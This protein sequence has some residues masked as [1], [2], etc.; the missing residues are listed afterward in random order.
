MDAKYDNY[1]IGLDLGTSAIKLV[2][3]DA[4]GTLLACSRQEYPTLGSKEGKA[5][6]RTGDWI[7][8]IGRAAD[9]LLASAGEEAMSRVSAI[10]LSAQ[11]PTMV[12]LDKKGRP[13]K[14]AVVWSDC[15][16]QD[17]GAEILKLFGAD[18]HYERT[19]VVLDGH[20]ILSMY[21]RARAEDPDFPK[22][23]KILSAKDYLAFYLTGKIATDPST[24]SGYGVYSLRDGSWDE[25]LCRTADVSSS[26]FPPIVDS[27]CICGR[28]SE[29]AARVMN[30]AVGTPV[31]TGG[32]DS[33]C[34]VFGMGVKQGTVCQMWGSSTAI[35]GVTDSIIL[36]P[37]RA[38]FTTPLLLKNTFAVEAD[39]MSTGVS[40]A[41]AENL[42]RSVGCTQG[43]TE[44]AAQAPPGSDGVL[45]Y[46]YL[47]GGEQ[48][49]LWDDGLTGCMLGLETQHGFPHILRAMLEGMCFEARRCMEAFE[50]GGCACRDVLCTGAVTADPF[51]MQLLCDVLGRACRV[52]RETSGSALGAAL[53]AG[54]AVGVW[55]LAALE[56]ITHRNGRTYYPQTSRE[57]YDAGY[58]RYLAYTASARVERR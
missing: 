20:Y 51:F 32:A 13:Y 4:D 12:V 42:L 36:S 33:V 37:N 40:Y 5:E 11:M 41:W 22:E 48:G 17:T 56:Q 54:A 7:D 30:L 26:V 31:I 44:L 8:A 3:V 28:L 21:L 10:G 55:S 39:L 49:V 52:T 9:S 43:I 35:L 47:A 14:N 45:F 57:A 46:P 16:A 15:R 23:P 1:I 2:L 6:Q 24:A 53:L 27:N 58:R 18:R 25:E 50:A 19:G 29:T 38:F 34:G